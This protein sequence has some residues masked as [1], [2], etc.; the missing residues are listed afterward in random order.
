MAPSEIDYYKILGLERHA[1]DE[2]IKRS[3]RKLGRSLL[4]TNCDGI[5]FRFL[6]FPSDTGW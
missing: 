2:D 3:F 5:S 4:C 6:P 1:K